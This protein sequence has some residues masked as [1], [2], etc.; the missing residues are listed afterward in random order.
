[1]VHAVRAISCAISYP[2]NRR[3]C[4]CGKLASWR[5]LSQQRSNLGP[6]VIAAAPGGL[7]GIARRKLGLVIRTGS[8]ALA[9][10]D[11]V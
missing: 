3:D 6:G 8:A 2:D 4:D 7:G 1:M 5:L 11:S 10:D 9:A